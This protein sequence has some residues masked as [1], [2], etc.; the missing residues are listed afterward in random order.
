MFWGDGSDGAKT[1]AQKKFCAVL[2]AVDL[3]LMLV[4][5]PLGI[6]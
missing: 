6:I 1:A 3:L 4:L 5:L 2:W